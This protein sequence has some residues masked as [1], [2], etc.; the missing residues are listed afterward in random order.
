[1]RLQLLLSSKFM[2]TTASRAEPEHKAWN[3]VTDATFLSPSHSNLVR[4]LIRIGDGRYARLTV[5][6][7]PHTGMGWW[8]NPFVS[9]VSFLLR[10]ASA[11]DDGTILV[12]ESVTGAC[13]LRHLDSSTN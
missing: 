13:S 4:A 9:P 12:W 5:C 6:I 1:M 10:F 2:G 3:P 7:Q 11:S 8:H